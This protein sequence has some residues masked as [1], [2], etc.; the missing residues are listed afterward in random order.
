MHIGETTTRFAIS[1]SRNLKGWN[2]GGSGRS[3]LAPGMPSANISPAC[4]TKSGA[5][6]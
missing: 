5:R 4:S 6:N 2:I 3:R 1:I